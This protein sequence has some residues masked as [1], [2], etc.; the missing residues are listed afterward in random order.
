[1]EDT[2]FCVILVGG[3]GKRLWPLSTKEKPKPFLPL[4]TEKPL[5]KET[6]DRVS[7]IFSSNQI[8]FVL[9]KEHKNLAQKIFPWSSCENYIIEPEPR[10]TSAA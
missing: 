6:L 10:D 3:P 1:M 7:D 5:I 9:S 4:I 2:I 8:R